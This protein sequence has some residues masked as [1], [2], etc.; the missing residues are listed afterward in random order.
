MSDG[1]YKT[2]PMKPK[3]K[4]AAKAAYLKAYEPSDVIEALETASVADYRS[5]V[6]SAFEAAIAKALIAP[7]QSHFFE[8]V[9]L[10][11]LNTLQ[12]LC[13]SPMEASLLDNARQAIVDG[14]SGNEALRQ[15]KRCALTERLLSASRQIEEHMFREAS[16]G[17]ARLVRSRLGEAIRR[18]DLPS[19]ESRTSRASVQTARNHKPVRHNGLDEGVSL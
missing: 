15:A 18:V 16:D 11:K 14:L 13:T 2:L 3:W 5:E 17:R 4:A 9:Q 7:R 8:N 10:S 12:A 1:P 6:S 19:I